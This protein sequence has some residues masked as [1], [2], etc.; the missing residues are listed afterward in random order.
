M[1]LAS[2]LL[3]GKTIL[4]TGCN[5]G[6]G[7]EIA[8]LFVSN[9]ALVYANARKNG[10]LNDL[11]SEL[12]N[13][14][15][16]NIIPVYFDVNDSDKLK[17]VFLRIIKENKRLDCLVNNAGIM[18]DA[19]IGMVTKELMLELFET[20]VFAVMDLTQYAVRLMR[21]E[22][23]GSII[24]I[25]SIAGISGNEGQI[26]YSSSKGAVNSMTKTAANELAKYNIRVNAIAPGVIDTD[27]ISGIDQDK[28]NLIKSKIGMGRHGNPID[29]A[30]LALFLA[31]D[32]SSYITGQIICVDGSM[33]V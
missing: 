20:N 4:I 2:K 32:L 16:E 31:S 29:V 15:S 1:E 6:I 25:S 24:N 21:R 19:L 5:R 27:L 8:K 7:Y 14:F 13:E 10:S 18:K 30:N 3:A 17:N 22:N 28:L 11:V 26:A 33:S 9:G 23:Y 12:Q